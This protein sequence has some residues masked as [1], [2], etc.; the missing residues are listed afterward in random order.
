MI[1]LSKVLHTSRPIEIE[2]TRESLARS[3]Q[4][5][6]GINH[7]DITLTESVDAEGNVSFTPCEV[8]ETPH[9][10]YAVTASYDETDKI[11][12]I[13]D[14]SDNLITDQVDKT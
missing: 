2:D 11:K 3:F 8:R 9:V 12:A 10:H 6:L 7:V 4:K 13:L 1:I 14:D 5:V